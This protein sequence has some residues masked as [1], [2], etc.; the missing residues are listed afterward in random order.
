[1]L[2]VVLSESQSVINNVRSRINP[3]GPLVVQRDFLQFCRMQQHCPT[4]HVSHQIVAQGATRAP[5]FG[6]II[7]TFKIFSHNGRVHIGVAKAKGQISVVD[8][9][10]APRAGGKQV[11]KKIVKETGKEVGT[12]ILENGGAIEFQIFSDS[13]SPTPFKI[14][15]YVQNGSV[16]T[17]SIPHHTL[18][19]GQIIASQLLPV[20]W[21]VVAEMNSE[22][23]KNSPR[24]EKKKW[25]N[26]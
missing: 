11:L 6:R 19:R 10:T 2:E 23:A 26:R 18:L 15:G 12:K 22:N 9:L 5:S 13:Q 17:L 16:R 1:M 3:Q 25:W 7:Q 21:T 14:S 4:A 20:H 24:V 8:I